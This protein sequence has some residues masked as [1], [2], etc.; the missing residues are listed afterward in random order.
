M[1]QCIILVFTFHW[2]LN[3]A[4][5]LQEPD[6]PYPNP[7]SVPSTFDPIRFRLLLGQRLAE[8]CKASNQMLPYLSVPQYGVP[9]AAGKLD[10]ENTLDLSISS[11][12]YP[13]KEL[14][15]EEEEDKKLDSPKPPPS[16]AIDL[17][18]KST[19]KDMDLNDSIRSD[20]FNVRN[21][22]PEFSSLA[23]VKSSLDLSFTTL[24]K[25]AVQ[26][27]TSSVTTT[28]AD[29]TS[30]NSTPDIDSLFRSATKQEDD[31]PVDLREDKR[32]LPL[33]SGSGSNRRKPAAPQ[34][35]DPGLDISPDSDIFEED[36]QENTRE[37]SGSGQVINGICIRQNDPFQERIKQFHCSRSNEDEK[38]K[39][40]REQN[41]RRLERAIADHEEGW[42]DISDDDDDD[43]VCL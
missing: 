43:E 28:S 36:P 35:V 8:M 16:T 27:L 12:Q 11:Q 10:A 37:P 23:S 18:D 3:Y 33:N 15:K 31:F 32:C 42:D 26:E 24:Q 2:S 21:S 30:R 17:T 20:K 5:L 9:Q 4:F 40:E 25:L 13:K 34:W 14:E 22:P 19:N 38:S 29:T 41:I 39:L 1:S 6:V 7:E